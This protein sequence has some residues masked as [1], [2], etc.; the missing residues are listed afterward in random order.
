MKEL[1]GLVLT[2]VLVVGLTIAWTVYAFKDCKKVG[3]S[4]LYCIGRMGQ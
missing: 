1:I 3:H 2:I 4:T